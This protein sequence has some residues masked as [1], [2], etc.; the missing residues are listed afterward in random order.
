MGLP[1]T[2][3]G[4]SDGSDS[5]GLLLKIK[6]LAAETAAF[7]GLDLQFTKADFILHASYGQPGYGVIT[8]A[9]REAIR[10]LARTEGIITD[11]VYTGRT[12]AGLIDL[13]RR[14][15]YTERETILYWHTGGVAGLFARAGEMLVD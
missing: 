8:P 7:L 3:E 10:L 12:L 6:A 9:E 15:V 4:V 5:A 11:P 14:G 1:L 2:V 13:I